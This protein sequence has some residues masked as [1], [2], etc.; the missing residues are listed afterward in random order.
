MF[1]G[2]FKSGIKTHGRIW[3][4]NVL[5]TGPARSEITF[6]L[7]SISSCFVRPSGCYLQH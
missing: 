3:V 5:D 2:A 1:Y 6:L 7:C 4:P